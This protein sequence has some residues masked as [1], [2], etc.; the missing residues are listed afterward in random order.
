MKTS[1]NKAQLII[2]LNDCLKRLR[3]FNEIYDSGDISIAKDIAVKLRLL[4]HNTNKSKSLIRQLKLEHVSFV[5]TADPYDARN[6]LTHHGL[7]QLN[8][9]NNDFSL[10]PML[11][12][13]KIRH[14]DFNNWWDS[15]KII[16]D[17]KKNVFT[18]RLIILELA[19]TDGGAHVDPELNEY[20]YDLSRAN[21]LGWTYH[22]VKTNSDQPLND[23][24]PPC[25]RQISYETELTF[26]D[27]D[28]DKTSRLFK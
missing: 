11:T 5:D 24:V 23:P 1:I 16:V 3:T 20:Y 8:C 18:R 14:V 2:Q 28:F 19:D 6:L 27:I 15:K 13:S 26:K 7:L 10:G 4:F 17:R 21:T 12:L 25:I 22:D 9:I